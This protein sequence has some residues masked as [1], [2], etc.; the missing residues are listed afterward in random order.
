MER[1]VFFLLAA[2]ILPFL[3]PSAF[4]ANKPITLGF[5]Y[6]S[7]ADEESW[8]HPHDLARQALA[9]MPGVKTLYKESVPEGHDAEEAIREMAWKGCDIVFTTSY[10]YMDPTLKVAKEFPDVTFL[11]CSGFKTAPNVSTYFA[12][13]YQARFLTGMAAGAMTKKNVIGYAAAFPIPEV[14]RGINAFTLGARRVNPDATVNVMWTLTWYDETKKKNVV[15]QLIDAGADVIAQ[16]RDS[17]EPQQAAEER[18]VY[19]V[20]YHA[21]MNR[22]AP[23]AHLVA[24]VW[25]WVPFYTEV[26][27]K[28]R[29]G[30]WETS[31]LWPGLESGIVDLSDFGPMVPQDV[32]DKILERKTAIMR[33][34]FAVFTGPI[35]DQNGRIRIKEGAVASDKELLEMNW[36][37]RGVIGV[38]P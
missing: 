27:E 1:F 11:H 6:G 28:V 10:G 16:H 12:R 8:S 9:A 34:K 22:F 14:I 25:N 21:D 38:T 15:L 17:P 2:F 31:Q 37:V 26:L 7:P 29:S 23:N 19:S 20:G 13:I 24:A 35:A 18:G 3:P 36:F 5:V 32:R 4:A 33:G 30:T